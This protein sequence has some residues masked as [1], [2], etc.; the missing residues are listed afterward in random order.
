M[1][2]LSDNN[3]L[4]QPFTAFFIVLCMLISACSDNNNNNRRSTLGVPGAEGNNTVAVPA[5]MIAGPIAGPPVLV[6][7]FIDLGSLGYTQAEYF[8]TGTAND[9]VNTNELQSNGKWQV[10][11]S[12]QDDYKTRIV[13][14]RPL[15]PEDF[16][17]TVCVEWLNG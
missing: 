12:E 1:T 6:S 13:V 7:T 10:Q 2:V 5:A 11:T 9:Y 8:V 4:R 17:G 3:A 16:N 14:I 15:A